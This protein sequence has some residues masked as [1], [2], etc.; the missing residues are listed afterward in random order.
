MLK[1]VVN[2]WRLE[3]K[4]SKAALARRI[5]VCRSYVTK[6][7]LGNLQPSGEMMFRI[8]E[9]FK[10]RVEDV[11]Q[12]EGAAQAGRLFFGLNMS[13]K[14]NDNLKRQTISSSSAS[15]S[16]RSCKNDAKQITT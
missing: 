12:R 8:A 14:G 11:F 9:Y 6:L 7:E 3:R 15:A 10:L 1:N 2:K 5:G 16:G 13:P 4:V